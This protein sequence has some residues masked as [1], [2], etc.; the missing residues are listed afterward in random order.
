MTHF[1]KNLTENVETEG[2]GKEATD[3]ALYLKEVSRMMRANYDNHM[4]KKYLTE[5]EC[6]E[7]FCL[8]GNNSHLPVEER[9][10]R[11]DRVF[12]IWEKVD[13]DELR[14]EME[15]SRLRQKLEVKKTHAGYELG[16][17]EFTL[18]YSPDWY[19]DDKAQFFMKQ[20]IE[21]LC[22][23]Y[24]DEIVYFRA[25]GE[26]TKADRVHIHAYYELKGGLKITDKNMKRAYAK[27]DS[28]HH[29]HKLVKK[30]SDFLGYIEKDIK[31]AWF[32]KTIDNRQK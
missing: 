5:G 29:H 15:L 13:F 6:W 17:R 19:N 3:D 12:E 31:G 1:P 11:T 2:K 18:T 25:V 7:L 26:K 24:S 22:A 23:Y 9:V 14:R 28:K 32:N 16:A 21:R 8:G 27:W 4:Y 20:A 10:R 30:T